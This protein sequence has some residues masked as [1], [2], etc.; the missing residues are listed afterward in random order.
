MLNN[1]L[2]VNLTND[3]ISVIESALRTQEKILSMQS[4]ADGD[5]TA[6]DRLSA[7]QQVLRT[8]EMQSAIPPQSQGA[9][10]SSVARSI[11]G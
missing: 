10:W 11:F 1:K 8:L 6:R 5:G 2:S 3:E 4:R 7:L 9:G